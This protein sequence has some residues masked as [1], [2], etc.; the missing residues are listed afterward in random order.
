MSQETCF[1]CLHVEASRPEQSV[2]SSLNGMARLLKHIA[3]KLDNGTGYVSAEK[4]TC[5][6]GAYFNPK[7]KT[8]NGGS[9][10]YFGLELADLIAYPVYVLPYGKLKQGI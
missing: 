7:W 3:N 2:I 4:L 1:C 9:E 5:I 8:R 6:S 10:S